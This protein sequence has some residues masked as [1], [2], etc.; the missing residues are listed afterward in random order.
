MCSH[1]LQKPPPTL[2]SSTI[3]NRRGT[4]AFHLQEPFLESLFRNKF[5]K[6]VLFCCFEK[7]KNG[8]KDDG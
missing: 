7:K 1:W 2:A 3:N 4:L 5:K 8:A 6:L